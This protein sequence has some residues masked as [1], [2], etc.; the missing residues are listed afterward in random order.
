[1]SKKTI[2]FEVEAAVII[3]DHLAAASC[4]LTELLEART[5]KEFKA[6]EPIESRIPNFDP[7]DLMKHDWKGKKIGEGQYAEGSLSWGW[8]FRDNFKPETIKALEADMILT[9]GENEFMLSGKIVQTKK[10]KGD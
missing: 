10:V 5:N 4:E 3:R 2:P 7:E 6:K 8:D 9:I 1:M